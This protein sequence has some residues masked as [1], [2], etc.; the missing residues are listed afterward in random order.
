MHIAY[1]YPMYTDLIE[2]KGRLTLDK[3]THALFHYYVMCQKLLEKA[4]TSIDDQ[5]RYEGEDW[6]DKPYGQIAK[7]IA[8]QYGLADAGE[9]IKTDLKRLVEAQV[10][11][12]GFPFPSWEYWVNINPDTKVTV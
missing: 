6:W 11:D 4:G 12:M 8:I 7:S 10:A 2:P 3:R 1:T 9:F 5:I